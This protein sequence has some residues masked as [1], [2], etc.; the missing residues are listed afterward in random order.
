MLVTG[1]V[2][3]AYVIF[4]EVLKIQNPTQKKKLFPRGQSRGQNLFL[5]SKTTDHANLPASERLPVRNILINR[6]RS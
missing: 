4:N 1:R 3:G 6:Q 5:I 2:R